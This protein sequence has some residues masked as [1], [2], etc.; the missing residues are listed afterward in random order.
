MR[1]PLTGEG[2]RSAA[3]GT[4]VANAVVAEQVAGGRFRGRRGDVVA[5]RGAEHMPGTSGARI[6]DTEII[7][8]KI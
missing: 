6:R 4:V 2:R 7:N 1:W 8:S 5:S 3:D